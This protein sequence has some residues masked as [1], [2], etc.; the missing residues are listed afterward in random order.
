MFYTIF[1][2]GITSPRSI[3]FFLFQTFSS[4][5]TIILPTE[6]IF[7]SIFENL[8]FSKTIS[9]P[10]IVKFSYFL[11]SI[12]QLIIEAIMSEHPPETIDK[13]SELSQ[14]IFMKSITLFLKPILAKLSTY[15]TVSL[16]I[17]YSAVN[18]LSNSYHFSLNLIRLLI[19]ID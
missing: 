3:I 19:G 13:L 17:F 15:F 5:I 14:H 6:F 4:S 12:T 7:I 11:M 16:S 1:V 9:L 18:A 8:S 10:K 2:S